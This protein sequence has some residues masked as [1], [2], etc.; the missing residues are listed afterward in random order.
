MISIALLAM[1][2]IT[3]GKVCQRFSIDDMPVAKGNPASVIR[4]VPS[5][6]PDQPINY[7]RSTTT[8]L[9]DDDGEISVVIRNRTDRKGV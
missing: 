2:P 9:T 3:T 6:V 1:I 4:I 8:K 7:A 5:P